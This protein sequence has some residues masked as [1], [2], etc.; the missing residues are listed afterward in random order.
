VFDDVSLQF[1]GDGVPRSKLGPRSKAM[2]GK[3]V[4]KHGVLGGGGSD[5]ARGGV[6]GAHDN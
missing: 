1:F 6:G 4:M 3:G 5:A 2:D